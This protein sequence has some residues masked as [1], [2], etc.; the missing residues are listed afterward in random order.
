MDGQESRRGVVNRLDW[1]LISLC[2]VAFAAV[3]IPAKKA[4]SHDPNTHQANEL[5]NARSK[6]GGLCCD[7]TDYTYVTPYS[8]ERT[9]KGYR[10]HL[11]GAWLEIP[12]DFEVNNMRNPDGEAKVWIVFDE[13]GAPFVRCFMPG[14]ES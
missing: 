12:K 3:V 2:C 14:M 1:L 8:W 9:E 6:Q 7:G 10:V 11:K 5:A 13:M 4:H